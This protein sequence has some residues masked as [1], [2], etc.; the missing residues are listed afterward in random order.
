LQESRKC[1]SGPPKR[2]PHALSSTLLKQL[3]GLF[4]SSRPDHLSFLSHKGFVG[5]ALQG[6]RVVV[7]GRVQGV[8]F[9]FFV[10]DV[11]TSLGLKGDVRNCWDSTVEISVEGSA[12]VLVDFIRAVEKGPPL[13]RVTRVEVQDIP[14]TRRYRSFTVE[15]M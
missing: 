14:V 9:R 8:G 11:G 10:Q 6:K 3:R 2:R 1:Q 13:S 4:E 5:M 15:G 12:E 7:H